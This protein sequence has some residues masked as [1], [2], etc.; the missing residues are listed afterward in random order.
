MCQKQVW[1]ES[2]LWNQIQI[3]F[4]C[5]WYGFKQDIK[6]KQKFYSGGMQ[7]ICKWTEKQTDDKLLPA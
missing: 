4:Y 3:F 6:D 5:I 2:W 7:T 1:V